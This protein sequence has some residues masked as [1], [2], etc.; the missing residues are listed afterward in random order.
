MSKQAEQLP[1]KELRVKTPTVLQMEAVECGAA[2]LAMILAYYRRFEPLEKLRETCGVSRDGSKASS[3]LKAARIYGLDAKGFR[4]EPDGIFEKQLPAILFW[5][6]YHFV[7]LEGYKDGVYFI[8][9]PASGPRKVSAEEFSDSFSGVLLT[10]SPTA[11]FK[12]GGKPFS[13]VDGLKKRLPGLETAL[14]YIVLVS[15]L[16]VIPGLV[17]PSF[18][19]IF[20]DYVLVKGMNGWMQ[21]L[22]VG[23]LV[24]A[25]LQGALAWLQQHYLLR[26]ETKLALTSSTKFFNHVF[27]LPIRFFSMRQAGE[28]SN[29]VQLNDKVATIVA[30]DL[31]SNGLNVLLIF[32]YALMMFRYDVVLTFVAILIAA[33]NGIALSF[34][35]SR[36]I[37]LNQ[38]FQQDN[39]KLLGT[40]FYGIKTIES[41]KATGSEQDFFSRWSG[42]FAN[43][44]AG[45]QTLEISTVFLLAIP[46]FLQTMGNIAILSAGGLRVMEGELTMGM[47]IAFQSLLLS[48]L[49]PVN[50]MVTL[51]QKLQEAS[52][53]MQRLDDVINN[54]A[55]LVDDEVI[56]A[57]IIG[58]S[59]QE[60][61]SGFVELKNVTF[62]YNPLEPP[63]ITDFSLK[64][65]PGARVALVGGSGSGKS[66]IAKIV[67][68]LFE[69]WSGEVLFDGKQR[70][71]IPRRVL[72]NSVGM[73]DQDITLF[74]GTIAENIAMWDS[75]L[76]QQ[77]IARASEDA[78]IHD[79]ITARTGGY[80]GVL[81][82]GGN[83]FSGGQ[84]QRME[85]ARALATD[86]SILILDEAT[87][88][89]D[90]ATEM[91][92]DGNI[93]RR[94]C[95]SL[96]VAHRLS[97]IRDCDEIIVLEYGVVKERGTH[98]TLMTK[99]GAY[100]RL[101]KTA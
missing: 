39:G 28:I 48:F 2:S 54:E 25:V 66:T 80:Q 76:P 100:A 57:T 78:A 10:F 72:V 24:T 50:Q 86:P 73:V 59:K 44:V 8:N 16:L 27:A 33:L 18:L 6:L 62:G 52:G 15:L 31:S 77:E 9:D 60:R 83:N 97:T 53:D 17:V 90:P 34:V 99:D 46:P 61:L 93:R 88:A 30:G 41:I 21:P 49:A 98:S 26:A 23:M 74:E 35:S 1:W 3:L 55:T 67:A 29:R 64:L 37:V 84:R 63:L 85:I 13:L 5:N 79:V 12:K 92:I 47:L 32:F 68:G 40:T 58:T 7:V 101:I 20:I 42:L 36:R 11:D 65:A 45:R 69:P 75:T 82:E 87:S 51:G 96:I 94:G 56:P 14:V 38:K 81:S 43:M 91:V 4:M 95:T 71:D 19:R 70:S 89:L 22:L